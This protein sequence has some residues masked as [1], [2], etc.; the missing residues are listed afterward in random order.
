MKQIQVVVPA[1]EGW[2]IR[3]ELSSRFPY[4]SLVDGRTTDLLLFAVGVGHVQELLGALDEQGVGKKHGEISVVDM[5]TRI[6]RVPVGLITGGRIADTELFDQLRGEGSIDTPFITYTILAALIATFGLIADNIVAVI[7]SM[8]V[9]PLLGP[10]INTSYGLLM[11]EERI[12]KQAAVTEAFGIIVSMFVGAGFA[13]ILVGETAAANFS[14]TGEMESRTAVSL[15]D[16]GIAVVGGLAAGVV[17]TERER[18][19][20]IGI[21]VAASLMPPATNIG[22]LFRLGLYYEMAG[23]F[24]LL[25]INLAAIHSA[26]LLVYWI[27]G[28]KPTTQWK[29]RVARKS[30]QRGIVLVVLLI[31]MISVPIIYLAWES[32]VE[33]NATMSVSGIVYDEL[34]DEGIVQSRVKTLDIN[35][36]SSRISIYLVL[37]LRDYEYD[38]FATEGDREAVANRI[39]NKVEDKMDKDCWVSI[40]WIKSIS[41]TSLAQ[42]TVRNDI[43]G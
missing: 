22:I 8:I 1:G 19:G 17:T 24:L 6:P 40:Q 16:I 31:I 34:E 25:L 27:R 12:W 9:A 15:L 29:A 2:R 41:S 36:D 37:A 4:V 5:T 18:A 30:I 13:F 20:I 11:G 7:A 10:I 42:P 26:L 35:I 38:N 3:D 14:L 23:C 32:Y 33:W 21:A 43:V 39:A 28:I